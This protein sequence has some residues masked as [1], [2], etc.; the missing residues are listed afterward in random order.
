VPDTLRF[1][2][3][4]TRPA[5]GLMLEHVQLFRHG[6]YDRVPHNP[7]DPLGGALVGIGLV[8]ADVGRTAVEVGTLL[9]ID[10]DR[11]DRDA[12]SVRGRSGDIV[13]EIRTP[14]DDE[15]PIG[16][17]PRIDDVVVTLADR[18]AI[19]AMRAR[20]AAQGLTCHDA[21]DDDA[22]M[23]IVDVRAELGH[24]IHYRL[25]A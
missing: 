7:G 1:A 17:A 10:F 13:V 15:P 12:P 23:L 4:D 3:A 24:A 5:L 18:E 25:A 2:Y 14:I 20:C 16:D 19:D 8:A 22:E 11:F 6:F 21:R 9:D